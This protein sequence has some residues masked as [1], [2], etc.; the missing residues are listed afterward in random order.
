MWPET[1]TGCACEQAG[2]CPR[3]RCWKTPDWHLLCRRQDA[4]FQAWERGEGPCLP[5]PTWQGTGEVTDVE[6]P[7][8][9]QRGL[10]LARA[11][12]RHVADGTA[13]VDDAAYEQRLAVCRQCPSCDAERMLCREPTCGCFL[14]IKA[15]WRS[16]SCPLSKWPAAPTAVTQ[17]PHR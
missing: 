14:T 2:W 6:G 3:H 1:L 12:A 7:G 17:S 4:Y 8:L 13:T 9:W 15:R 5:E 16:E 10:N 11:L